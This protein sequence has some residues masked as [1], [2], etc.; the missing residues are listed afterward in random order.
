MQRRRARCVELRCKKSTARRYWNLITGVRP[1]RRRILDIGGQASAAQKLHWDIE[2][3]E[4][5]REGGEEGRKKKAKW[6]IV[7]ATAAILRAGFISGCGFRARNRSFPFLFIFRVSVRSPRFFPGRSHSR[8]RVV[9]SRRGN[10]VKAPRERGCI[11]RAAM[12]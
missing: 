4:L 11:P 9:F 10:D 12:T 5:N 3:R 8:K 6:A 2:Y 1:P 7:K